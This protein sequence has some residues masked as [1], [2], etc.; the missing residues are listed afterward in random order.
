MSPPARIAL[1]LISHTNNGKTTL[2]RTLLGMDVGE[3]RD[4]AHV[5]EFAQSHPV[6]ESAQGDTLQLWDT[7]GFGDS[8][9]LQ[10]RLAK[11]D[12]P[13]GWFLREV[14]DRYRDR[15]LWLSQ[16]ALRAARDDTDIVLYLVN[17]AEHPRDTGYLA[18]EMQILAWLGKPV[19]VLLNQVGAPRPPEVE[20]AEQALW[21]GHLE[22]FSVVRKVLTLD[23]FSRCWVHERV[24]YEAMTPLLPAEKR[25][26]Y[27]RLLATWSTDNAAR[28]SR[29]I[30][31]TSGALAAAAID[32][33]AIDSEATSLLKT[34]M[35]AVGIGKDS[36]QQR[37]DKAMQALLE[38]LN[39]HI[40]NDTAALLALHKLDPSVANVIHARV[41][42]NFSIRAPIDKAQAGL[43]GAVLSGAASGLSADL[44]AGGLTLGAGALLGGVVGAITFAGA[45]W[46]F[47]ASTDRQHPTVQ[48]SE[49]FLRS[50]LVT[51]LLRYLAIA[52]FGRGRGQFVEGEA[53]AFWQQAVEDAVT[54]NTVSL[55]EAWKTMRADGDPSHIE[56]LVRAIAS[57]VLSSLY[58]GITIPTR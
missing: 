16:Q 41:R 22:Q 18:P 7:P 58:P 50:L 13:L 1:T 8:V 29:V 49:E 43:L 35:K 34:A 53:P 15:T 9:R 45:A 55:T 17:A 21:Q 4:A 48:F 57:R 10:R 51:C 31:I 19:V 14:L 12:G 38:R 5:T 44:V 33:Q 2:A 24:F 36:A 23:A 40:A 20:Q 26:G 25:E 30:A 27:A 56:S 3:V 11:A 28:F 47:N 39:A 42:D 37:Q 46:G 52:H 32:R 54:R 6:L